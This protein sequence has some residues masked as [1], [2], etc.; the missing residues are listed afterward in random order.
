MK[1]PSYLI[2]VLLILLIIFTSITGCKKAENPIK[3]PLGTF[4][5]SVYNLAGLNSQYDDKNSTL[6]LIGNT[7]PIIFSSNRGSLGGQFDLVQ[8]NIGFTFDQTTGSFS[9]SSAMSVDPFYASLISQANTAGND[10]GPLDHFSSADGN[11]YLILASQDAGDSLDLYYLKYL[12]HFNDNMPV[13]HGPFAAKVFNTEYNEAYISFD[14]NEDSAYFSS[15]RNGKYDIFLQKKPAGTFLDTWFNRDFATSILVDSV[16][17]S[18][19]DK[20]PFVY[21]NIMLFIS[22]RLG[23]MGGYDIY[24]SVFKNGNWSSPVNMGPRINTASDEYR[25]ILGYH[26]GF[27][28]MFMV[29]SSDKP[30]GK[31]GFDLYFTGVNIL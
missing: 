11:E 2:L 27:N 15:D 19:D 7:F 21:K 22:N 9:V 5:D 4:P 30:G 16:N 26:P 31:N 25:P 23:G 17:S 10:F 28:N 3:Y 18:S 12:P 24:Y 29:F 13:V 8:G 14:T 20:C 1:K 6:Y